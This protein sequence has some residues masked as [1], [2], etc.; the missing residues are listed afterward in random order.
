[1]RHA[2]PFLIAGLAATAL[3]IAAPHAAAAGERDAAFFHNVEG[4]WTG[5]G[6]IVAG[7]YKG[8]KFV[9]NFE[10]STPDG[11]VGMALD[12]GC[13]VGMFTQNM[14]ATVERSGGHYRGTFLDGAKGK[15]LD[16]IDGD[17]S[18][19]KVVF[20]LNRKALNGAMLAHLSDA[21]TMNITISVKVDRQLVPV[22]GVNLKRVERREADASLTR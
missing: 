21:N 15:G 16:V 12:G 8:T 13:R 6:E 10:G 20:E 11:K 17:V 5:P 22:I 19:S 14:S 18:G 7:K 4:K 1:M 3:G 2:R 9:C